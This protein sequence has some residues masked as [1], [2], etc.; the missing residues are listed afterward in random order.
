MYIYIYIIYCLVHSSGDLFQYLYFV[1]KADIVFLLDASKQVGP[2]RFKLELSLFDTVAQSFPVE[3]DGVYFGGIAYAENS[4]VSFQLNDY[5]NKLSL[6]KAIKAITFIGGGR[7]VGGAISSVKASIFDKSGRA[8]VPKIVVVLMYEKSDDDTVVP[9]T[10]L[11][12]TGIKL[13]VLG[14]GKGADATA[15]ASTASSADF[16]LTQNPMRL[17]LTITAPLV[18][19]INNGM[20]Y[21]R[22]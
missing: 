4:V 18:D 21:F 8:G 5:T 17:L 3:K 22:N 13:I 15:L 14:L 20:L 6:S 19:K 1:D 10:A 9:A 11:K 7:K 12:G 2:R 16:V